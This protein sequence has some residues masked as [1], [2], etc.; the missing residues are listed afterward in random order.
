M[1]GKIVEKESIRK[2]MVVT[3]ISLMF[4]IVL[5][6]SVSYVSAYQRLCL[7]YGQSVPSD[8]NA[9]YTCFHDSCQ[10]CVTDSNYPTNPNKCN[11]VSG[12]LVFGESEVDVTPPV[13]TIN[14]P[15]DGEVFNSRKVLFDIEGNEPASMSYL[16]NINGRGRW[17]R[18]VSL[19]SSYFRERSMKEGLNDITI[20]GIDR[21]RNEVEEVV[22]FFVD[23]RDPKIRRT[24]PKRGFANGIFEVEFS[25]ANVVD[26]DLHYGNDET[27]YRSEDVDLDNCTL[28]RNKY[29]CDVAVLLDDYSGQD[30][31]YWF[32]IEDIA[33]N[34][35]EGRHVV[36]GVDV[37]DPVIVNEDFWS[38]GEGRYNRYIYFNIEIDEDNFDEVSIYDN[39]DRRPRWKR[40]CSRLRED[41]CIKKVSFKT[42]LH[43]VDV[44][45]MDE[46]GNAISRRIEFEV[47]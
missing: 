35:D 29:G 36:L 2:G 1:F 38:Q 27:G 10:I 14:S 6:L 34:V 25:E 22:T 46:A 41:R 42:G 3:L 20:K 9:R 40:I 45:V 8:E 26:L 37:E 47:V 30:I 7:N 11:D 43:E 39:N 24:Y 18:L 5:M 44:Q 31:E 13:L 15:S 33:G 17:K 21:N 16:D 32:E 28:L 23:S 4:L 12:C 19:A